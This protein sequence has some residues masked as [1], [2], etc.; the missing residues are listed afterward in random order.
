M[1][2]H[3][4]GQSRL[5]FRED[6]PEE[7]DLPE[8]SVRIARS[9]DGSN[10]E[11]VRE[12]KRD[13]LQANKTCAYATVHLFRPDALHMW[14]IGANKEDEPTLFH[15]IS[16][17][18]EKWS[19]PT[20]QLT[21]EIDPRPMAC[22]RIEHSDDHD[23]L[24]Y[25]AM[26]EDRGPR[27]VT[28]VSQNARDWSAGEPSEFSLPV[29]FSRSAQWQQAAP[30]IVFTKEGARLY[31]IDILFSRK[32]VKGHIEKRD[33]VRGAVLRTAFCPKK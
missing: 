14:W 28:K 23:I 30:S 13:F 7:L 17:N 15:S 10:W 8:Q 27:F 26:D 31:Y 29:W 19:E 18:G 2:A 6:K 4:R 22:A 33:A 12:I 24:T 16:Q 1:F 32:N 21:R 5:A 3:L 25:V 11:V 9:T 20:Q